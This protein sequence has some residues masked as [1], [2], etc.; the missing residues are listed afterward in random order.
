[1]VEIAI[2]LTNQKELSINHRHMVGPLTR[3]DWFFGCQFANNLPIPD[4]FVCWEILTRKHARAL[5][6]SQPDFDI[7]KFPDLRSHQIIT[8]DQFQ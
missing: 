2:R 6:S 7:S 5:P 4:H 3:H 8:F 1:M